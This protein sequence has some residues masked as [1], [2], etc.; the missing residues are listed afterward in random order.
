MNSGHWKRV[1]ILDKGRVTFNSKWR[2]TQHMII[3]YEPPVFGGV[4]DDEDMQK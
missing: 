3:L 1:R 2:K 4:R